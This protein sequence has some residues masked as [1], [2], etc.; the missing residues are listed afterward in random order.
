[1]PLEGIV[2]PD[3]LPISPTLRLRRYTDGS[4]EE[5]FAAALPWYQDRELVRLVDGPDA[6]PYDTVEKL[7]GMYNYLDTH[8]ELYWIEELQN[9]R[10]I[11]IGDVTLQREDMPIVLGP[12]D[13]RGRGTG[14]AVVY[15]LIRRA[16]A[17]GWDHAAVRE[18]YSY[19]IASRKLFLSCGFR[20]T[21]RTELGNSYRLDF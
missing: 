8:G 5:D 21:G 19:N 18:I 3:I 2:Q 11:P 15:T 17:L 10:F 1:M 6:R 12:A 4:S 13:C 9:S 20:E 7:A 16:K 14:K